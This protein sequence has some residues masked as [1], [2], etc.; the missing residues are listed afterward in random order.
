MSI[1]VR[2]DLQLWIQPG[3]GG[4]RRLDLQIGPL[5]VQVTEIPSHS[6]SGREWRVIG[7]A[8]RSYAAMWG[9][10]DAIAEDPFDGLGPSSIYDAYHYIAVVGDRL[11]ASRKVVSLRKVALAPARMSQDQ[12][13]EPFELLP[14]DVQFY[15]S[16]AGT[17]LWWYLGNYAREL[18]PDRPRAELHIASISRFAAYPRGQREQSERRR[19]RTVIAWAA[20]QCLA[21]E[22]ESSL[23]YT[24]QMPPALHR[25]VLCLVD[26]SGRR[27]RPAQP[28]TEDTLNLPPESL[29]L[30]RTNR[31]VLQYM[32]TLPGYFVDQASVCELL[33]GLHEHGVIAP[34]D[35]LGPLSSLSA[36]SEEARAELADGGYRDDGFETTV[37]FRLLAEALTRPVHLKHLASRL[38]SDEPFAGVSAEEFRRLFLART[39][40]RPRSYTMHPAA[41]ADTHKSLLSA[42]WEKY[43]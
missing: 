4:R 38:A 6:I 14:V 13:E 36:T 5:T 8:R 16:L 22:G 11:E 27:R 21:A 34:G 25:R 33:T 31:H 9:A 40:D 17:P 30:D 42:A 15:R 12:L 43:A 7:Q 37:E 20:I 35:F 41:W 32:L 26:A 19:E 2:D 18:A 3:T 39:A 24:M 29:R 23:L 28:F 10:N 1:A